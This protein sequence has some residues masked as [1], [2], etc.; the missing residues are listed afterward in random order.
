MY[1]SEVISEAKRFTV[2]GYFLR[3]TNKELYR[4]KLLKSI[5]LSVNRNRQIG[6]LADLI[7][8]AKRIFTFVVL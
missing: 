1:F 8:F 7:D 4:H 2:L 3:V 6:K 5:N